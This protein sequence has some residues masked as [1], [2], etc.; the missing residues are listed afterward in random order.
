MKPIYLKLTAAPEGGFAFKGIRAAGFECP[1]QVHPEYELILVLKGNGYRIVGD[2]VAPIAPP[3]L[4]LLGPGLP[5]IWQ[6][7]PTGDRPSG[8]HVLLIQFGTDFLNDSLLKLPAFEPLRRLLLE[9]ARRGIHFGGMTCKQVTG[10][11]HGMLKARGPERILLFLRILVLLAESTDGRFLASAGFTAETQSYDQNRMDRV[12]QFM[13]TCLDRAVRLSEVARIACLSEGAFSRFFRAH[14]GKTFT[15]F[16]NELRIGRA[17]RLL[18]ESDKTITEVSYACGFTN[19]SNFN[20]QFLRLKTVCPRQFRN[21]MQQ[22]MLE[23]E[24]APTISLAHRKSYQHL[25]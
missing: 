1:W 17:C 14:T 23:E 19:L 25:N 18:V 2:S 12:M 15:R 20:R 24:A 16:L 9:R 5:H 8:V 21:Q 22:R 4:V 10:L 13:N 11:M 6:N 7:D 3:D